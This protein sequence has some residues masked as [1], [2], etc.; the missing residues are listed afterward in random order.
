MLRVKLPT[1]IT[2]ADWDKLWSLGGRRLHKRKLRPI[3]D[4]DFEALR[5]G[6]DPHAGGA[7]FWLGKGRLAPIARTSGTSATQST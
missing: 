1:L 7:P 5:H 2:L 3:R 6:I 4:G